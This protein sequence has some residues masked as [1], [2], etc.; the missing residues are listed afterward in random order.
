MIINIGTKNPSKIS[1]VKEAFKL[2]PKYRITR[3][4][5]VAVESI[6]S[7]QPITLN[8]TIKGARH[9]AKAAFI[10]CDMSVGIESG[11]MKVPYSNTGYMDYT[12]TV[13][14][15]GKNYFMGLSPAF[16]YPKVVVIDILKKKIDS[17][18]SFYKNKLTKHKYI[19]FSSGIIGA[20]TKGRM[21]R[22]EYTRYSIIMAMIQV[23]NK[24]LY[25]NSGKY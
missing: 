10:K 18:T 6:V 4:N 7:T 8:E 13:I 17:S 9:R 14:Y 12:V 11:L 20:L 21:I 19:G 15:D 25:I 22:S 3:F 23:E 2:Y 1:A 24:H 16:E 5:P